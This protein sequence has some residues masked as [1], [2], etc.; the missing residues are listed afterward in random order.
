MHYLY[1]WRKDQA[2]D[3]GDLRLSKHEIKEEMR[4]GAKTGGTRSL[5]DEIDESP[6]QEWRADFNCK[7]G[8]CWRQ[9]GRTGRPVGHHRNPDA[10]CV[11]LKRRKRGQGK[12]AP[13]WEGKG[14]L[15]PREESLEK[16]ESK[17]AVLPSAFQGAGPRKTEAGADGSKNVPGGRRGS[18]QVR[19]GGQIPS[20]SP[21]F[22]RGGG[23]RSWGNATGSPPL[24]FSNSAKSPAH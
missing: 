23:P 1:Q 6:P 19:H 13:H 11:A 8:K 14:E 16:E 9:L 12:E 17:G 5:K 22:R 2:D 10:L 4:R 24:L 7:E 15:K 18:L 3:Q 21:L 20:S